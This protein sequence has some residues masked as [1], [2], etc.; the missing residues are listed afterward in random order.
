VP[1]RVATLVEKQPAKAEMKEK[2][3]KERQAN[4][5]MRRNLYTNFMSSQILYGA[6]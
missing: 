3:E 2:K 6:S 4:S 5:A 1:Q